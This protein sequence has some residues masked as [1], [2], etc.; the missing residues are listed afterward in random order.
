M[1]TRRNVGEKVLQSVL[2]FVLCI[3][4][5][6]LI[7]RFWDKIVDLAMMG[8]RSHPMRA[9]IFLFLLPGIFAYMVLEPWI[10]FRGFKG[11]VVSSQL[12]KLDQEGYCHGAPIPISATDTKWLMRILNH[13]ADY[14]YNQFHHCGY[15]IHIET[16]RKEYWFS[17]DKADPCLIMT[18]EPW[19]VCEDCME[20]SKEDSRR[21]Q[22][23]LEKYL[24]N[25]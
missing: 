21:L 10:A 23:I 1:K 25:A 8:S 24:L 22:S 19:S 4:S 15:A 2:C 17:P 18:T 9:V 20:I 7:I 5:V 16:T 13:K 3:V 11:E 12:I 14:H 6:L